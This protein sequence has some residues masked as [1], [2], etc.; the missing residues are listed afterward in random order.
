M[1]KRFILSVIASLGM[2][3]ALAAP[4]PAAAPAA[5]P[6]EAALAAA[7]AVR[8]V[9]YADLEHLVGS[10][11]IVQTSLKT[12]RRGVLVK[13]TRPGIEMRIGGEKGYIFSLAEGDIVGSIGVLDA[14]ADEASA[15][16]ISEPAR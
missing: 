16:A 9:S 15:P 1:Q 5:P 3:S 14:P 11:I 8:A 4:P 6:T 7:R 12:V 2:A 13:F 10:E